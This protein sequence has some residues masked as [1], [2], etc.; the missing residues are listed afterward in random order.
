LIDNWS[1]TGSMNYGR[2]YHSATVL[3]NGKV[4]VAGGTN[5]YTNTLNSAELYDPILDDGHSLVV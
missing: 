4:L 1:M 5:N 2:Y 3:T